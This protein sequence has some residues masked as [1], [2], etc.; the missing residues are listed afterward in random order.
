MWWLPS[1]QRTRSPASPNVYDDDQHEHEQWR[2]AAVTVDSPAFT[3]L[4]GNEAA[5][6]AASHSFMIDLTDPTVAIR[7]L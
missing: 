5:A 6:G 7:F 2:G 1:R 3:D 4:A